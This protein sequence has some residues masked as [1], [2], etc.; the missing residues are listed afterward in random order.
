MKVLVLVLSMLSLNSTAFAASMKLDLM[1]IVTS[2][3]AE[4]ECEA[5]CNWM[6]GEVESRDSKF[7][8]YTNLVCEVRKTVDENEGGPGISLGAACVLTG[9]KKL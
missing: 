8:T 2:G 7:S 5:R 3:D 4:K 9:I 6:E 1:T